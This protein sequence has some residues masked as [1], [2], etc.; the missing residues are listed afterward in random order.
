MPAAALHCWLPVLMQYKNGVATNLI[1]AISAALVEPT[2]QLFLANPT[3][4]AL[5][6]ACSRHAIFSEPLELTVLGTLPTR[7]CLWHSAGLD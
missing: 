4:Q 5:H 6:K 3:P 7:H 1:V 2:Y